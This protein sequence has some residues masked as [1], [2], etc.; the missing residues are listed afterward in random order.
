MRL[1]P[2]IGRS[3]IAVALLMVAV[4]QRFH[5]LEGHMQEVDA[6]VQR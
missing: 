1:C 6:A 2:C 4:L 3:M 5:H